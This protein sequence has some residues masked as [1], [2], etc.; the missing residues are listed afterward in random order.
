MLTST[1]SLA[2]LHEDQHEDGVD[3]CQHPD[4]PALQVADIFRRFGPEYRSEFGHALTVQ[5]DRALREILVCR[6]EALGLRRWQCDA[7]GVHTELFNSCIMGS[8]WL[9]GVRVNLDHITVDFLELTPHYYGLDRSRSSSLSGGRNR[10]L[11]RF[12]GVTFS[13]ASSFSLGSVRV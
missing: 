4:R 10:P 7:C 3:L 8:S 9:W 5:Q 12:G 1:L 2:E 13:I 11:R 6:T